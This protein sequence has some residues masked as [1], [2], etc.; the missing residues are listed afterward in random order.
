MA[1]AAN[2]SRLEWVNAVVEGS[3]PRHRHASPEGSAPRGT[4]CGLLSESVSQVHKVPATGDVSEES[5]EHHSAEP[6]PMSSTWRR[7]SGGLRFPQYC[8]ILSIGGGGEPESHP[9]P[10]RDQLPLR[11]LNYSPPKMNPPFAMFGK[12]PTYE[13]DARGY[14]RR[15]P[16]CC[17]F[18]RNEMDVR[19]PM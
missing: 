16:P 15:L 7:R 6:R 19:F 4:L 12:H 18:H 5:V 13:L 10:K 2:R 8:E 9:A 1:S 3:G 14:A 11:R 17:C